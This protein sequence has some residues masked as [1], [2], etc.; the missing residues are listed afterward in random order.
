MQHEFPT[1]GAVVPWLIEYRAK[2]NSG[3]TFAVWPSQG[4]T[5][6]RVTYAQFAHACYRFGRAICPDPP[7]KSGD[8]VAIIA[9]CDTLLY[10]A[11][12]GGLIS[13]GLTVCCR[14]SR[15]H[16]PS[17]HLQVFPVSPRLPAA[18]ICHL[19]RGVSA[20]RLLVTTSFLSTLVADVRDALAKADYIVDIEEIPAFTDIYPHLATEMTDEND[21]FIRLPTSTSFPSG[22]ELYLHSS[23]STGMPKAVPCSHEFLRK[24]RYQGVCNPFLR[25]NEVLRIDLGSFDGVPGDMGE[26]ISLC[27][28]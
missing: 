5:P 28:L 8:V 13:A 16:P 15:R 6:S 10:T 17:D 7:I 1:T 2:N 4:D 12:I 18:A 3:Q 22:I 11:A 9:I 25:L 21:R 23:G 19:L 20:R 26:H 24:I 14:F 27:N